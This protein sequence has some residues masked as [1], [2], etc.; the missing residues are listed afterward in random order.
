M[1]SHPGDLQL[2]DGPVLIQHGDKDDLLIDVPEP[3]QQDD[4][5][6]DK[7]HLLLARTKRWIKEMRV[8]LMLL[9]TILASLAYLSVP[10]PPGGLFWREDKAGPYP[11]GH[12]AGDPVLPGHPIFKSL[13]TVAFLT[14]LLL[15]SSECFYRTWDRV[16]GLLLLA[17]LDLACLVGAYVVGASPNGWGWFIIVVFPCTVVACSFLFFSVPFIGRVIWM[18]LRFL[19]RLARLWW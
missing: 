8:G 11:Y 17:L 18:L 3:V 12:D 15:V 10:Y 4:D 7:D 19:R 16:A 9:A 13:S 6:D 5:D 2:M 1:S 14:S